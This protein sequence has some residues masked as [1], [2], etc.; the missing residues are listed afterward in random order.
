MCE[1]GGRLSSKFRSKAPNGLYS[2]FVKEQLL[3]ISC[4]L[5]NHVHMAVSGKLKM[6][7]TC[8]QCIV[9]QQPVKLAVIF[10]TD[11]NDVG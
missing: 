1:V 6:N 7:E 2:A 11:N 3:L 4:F 8:A 10:K 5:L 9:L